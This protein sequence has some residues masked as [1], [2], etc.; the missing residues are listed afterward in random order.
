MPYRFFRAESVIS[1][2]TPA[3][4][5]GDVPRTLRQYM[6]DWL[7]GVG[8]Y[9]SFKMLGVEVWRYGAALL[10]LVAAFFLKRVIA[11]I[12]GGWLKKYVSNT[13][14]RLDDV[15]VEAATKPVSWAVV[16]YGIYFALQ[17]LRVHETFKTHFASGTK[18][19]LTFL[20]LLFILKLIDGL[21]EY[22]RPTIERTHT[23]LDD[24]VLPAM[25]TAAK[26][27]VLV[28][29]ILAILA[30]LEY[31]ITSI[32]TGLGIGGLAI[33]LAAQETLSNWFGAFMIFSDRPFAAGD[34]VLVGDVDGFVEQVG[35][36]STRI[37][38]LEGTQV[39]IPNSTVA[40]TEIN[41]ISR[42][43]ARKSNGTIGLT[44]DTTAEKMEEALG[45]IRSIL[46]GDKNVRDDFLAHFEDF[47]DYSLNI[48]VIYWALTV[49]YAEFLA[50]KEAV[51]LNIMKR[52]AKAGIEIA[53]PTQT[54][55]V[56]GGLASPS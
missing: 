51:N 8:E 27:F 37:R 6:P 10:I 22:L 3:E 30:N 7:V 11:G 33:A 54:L 19:A 12:V 18:V 14:F 31:N 25:K 53:F 23:R 26:I 9:F 15:I 52:F 44:Y 42:M 5:P 21:V 40:K 1:V 35:L 13:R 34:R 43:P 39:T 47:A 41:N 38:T 36:R 56:K 24:A 4:A 29:G 46:A 32:L 2:Q 48:R 49:D 16:L 55:Y 50:I 20:V 17:T 45:I 28:I